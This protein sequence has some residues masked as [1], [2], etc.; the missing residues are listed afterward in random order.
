MA[1]PAAA[2]FP[3]PAALGRGAV[4]G[5]G[6]GAP[7]GLEHAPRYRL[8]AA[9]LDDPGPLAQLLHH[10]WVARKPFVV[11][12][13]VDP[14]ALTRRETTDLP[15]W[16]LGPWFGFERERLAHRVW[17]NS[18][19]CRHD[20][21]VWWRGELAVRHAGA[22]RASAG[23]PGDVVLGDGTPAWIDGGPRGP[24]AGLADG[25]AV[26]HRESVDLLRRTGR[27]LDGPVTDELAPDQ[28]A[29]VAHR[30]GPARILAPA[31]SG[32]TRVLTAR[33]HHLLQVRGVEPELVTAV[34]Y[35]RR[36]AEELRERVGDERAHVRTIHSLAYAIC[37]EA[38]I[39]NLLDERDV[40]RVLED[41]VSVAR[42]PNTDPLQ[43]WLEALGEVRLGL[44]DPAAVETARGDVDGLAEVVPQY[45]EQLARRD[46]VDFDE[47]LVRAIELLCTDPALRDRWRLRCTHLL[48]DEFQD[49]TPAFLLLLRLLAWPDLQVFGVGDDDQVIYGHA[50]ADPAWLLDYDLGFPGAADHRLEVNYRCPPSVVDGAVRLLAHN[51]RRVPKRIVAG[52]AARPGDAGLD[53]VTVR[54]EDGVADAVV[55][56]VRGVVDAGA[57]PADVVVLARVNAALLPF[58][59]LLGRAGVPTTAPLDATILQRT[60]VRAA[61]AYLRIAADGQDVARNDLFETVNRPARK[62]RSALSPHLKRHG[63]WSLASLRGLGDVLSDAAADRLASWCDELDGLARLRSNGAD[64]AA[65]LRHVRDVVGLGE[66]M[67]TL[68]AARGRADG[69][70]HGDDLSA[71]LALARHHTDP[72]TF[73]TWLA[74]ELRRPGD[75]GGVLLSSIHR[76][77]GMEWDHVVVAPASDGLFPH[78]LSEGT[79]GEEEERRVFHVAVTR[80]RR[81]VTVVA[82]LTRTSPFVDE[83]R[84]P[85]P[86]LAAEPGPD[87]GRVEA[88]GTVREVPDTVDP[89]RHD[90]GVVA[91]PGL[92]VELPGGVPAV[93]LQVD[94]HD[95][96][97]APLAPDGRPV[98]VRAR[99]ALVGATA[100]PPATVRVAGDDVHLLAHPPRRSGSAAAS[101]RLP[102]DV[103]GR[104]TDPT[105]VDPLFAALREWRTEVARADAVPPYVVFNDATLTA[106]AERQPCDERELLAVKGVGPSKLERFGDDV[107]TIVAD[108]TG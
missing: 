42:I 84:S 48:V 10:H 32:K 66:A 60:G 35:N 81:S 20:D 46:A 82:P 101:G 57:R 31:G 105:L 28:H 43:P 87:G 90:D 63:N 4:V 76:V 102:I 65:L 14:A 99:V 108:H 58:Q 37:R 22:T 96:L 93:V 6:G 75:P 69:S 88:D 68:D 61:L 103:G 23:G 2:S 8:D 74:E 59:V 40:R 25:Q 83:L 104:T 72:S 52:A 27:V 12:L 53:V 80:G 34:A 26:V 107:L 79:A 56:A 33:L 51:R 41:L 73:G 100:G 9:A 11:E 49:L 85:A 98:G 18:Y 77:K 55:E 95:A 62:L 24:V 54:E 97:V 106:I 13:A 89:A 19:D 64:T 70:S 7:V 71:L 5:V 44:R 38:G 78:R 3:G 86:D 1:V 15:P 47:Q 94:G 50:G 67:D 45:R 29:A 39:R 92:R 91:E 16:R 17:A 36:A 21:P 30:S